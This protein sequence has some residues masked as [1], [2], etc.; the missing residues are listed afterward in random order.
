[1]KNAFQLVAAAT[2][3]FVGGYVRGWYA[4]GAD[5]AEVKIHKLSQKA[6]RLRGTEATVEE[7][8]KKLLRIVVGMTQEDAESC[9]HGPE[10]SEP[11]TH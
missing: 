5:I 11:A 4:A 9:V 8:T 10:E 7:V 3:S 1:M 2:I 6:K